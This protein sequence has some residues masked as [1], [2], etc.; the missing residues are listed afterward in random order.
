MQR[1]EF[2]VPADFLVSHEHESA[3]RER[4]KQFSA[5]IKL[6]FHSYNSTSLAYTY[7]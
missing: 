1:R 7:K 5:T 6:N 2:S 4:T 3:G